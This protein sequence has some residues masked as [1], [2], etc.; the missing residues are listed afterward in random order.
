MSYLPAEKDRHDNQ[1]RGPQTLLIDNHAEP[2]G[3]EHNS[4]DNPSNKTGRILLPHHTH[5]FKQH[6]N[7]LLGEMSNERR[8]TA[9]RDTNSDSR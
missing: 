7:P 3:D 2:C 8:K 6:P 4:G 5:T 1:Q 9:G